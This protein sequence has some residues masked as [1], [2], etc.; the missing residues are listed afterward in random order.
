MSTPNGYNNPAYCHQYDTS[1]Y[2]YEYVPEIDPDS[3]QTDRR[4]EQ[5]RLVHPRYPELGNFSASSEEFDGSDESNRSIIVEECNNRRITLI[6]EKRTKPREHETHQY[7]ENGNS[8]GAYYQDISLESENGYRDDR[9][10][11]SRLRHKRKLDPPV[12]LRGDNQNYT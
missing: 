4:I 12:E 3:P 6:C 7:L 11:T 2:D 9:E 8:N 1:L 5:T 10:E